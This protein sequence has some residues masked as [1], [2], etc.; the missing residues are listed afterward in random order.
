MEN[1]VTD[2]TT[3]TGVESLFH[4]KRDPWGSGLAG[5]LADWYAYSADPTFVFPSPS[6]RP[7]GVNAPPIPAI[8]EALR[9]RDS[10]MM[11]PLVCPT[12]QQLTLAD[13]FYSDALVGFLSW[14]K[15]NRGSLQKWLLVHS[16][17]WVTGGHA[18]RI[19]HRYLYDMT[20]VSS[21]PKFKQSSEELNISP[22][23]LGY[24]LD[25]AL[26]YARYGERVGNEAYYLSHPLREQQT[27]PTM[28][29]EPQQS[30]PVA[31]SFANSVS[32]I[33]PSLTL[34]GYSSLLHEIMR[35]VSQRDLR[36]LKPNSI[37]EQQVRAVAAELQLPVRLK[38]WAKTAGISAAALGGFAALPTIATGAAVAG[39]VVGIA[40]IFWDG[41]VP[42]S[43]GRL[44]WLRWGLEWRIEEEIK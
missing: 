8:V 34:D 10:S 21:M 15:N 2:I 4:Q 32:R 22:D 44:N 23:N 30:P 33:A 19:P 40:A 6:G 36:S 28:S 29:I 31:L 24:T 18:E 5:K 27:L 26:R 9:Q 38:G 42:R 41:K 11:K 25:V 14:C 12:D 3:L 37:E 17:P 13:E 7:A 43:L 1:W 16:E 35:V 20:K 39:A